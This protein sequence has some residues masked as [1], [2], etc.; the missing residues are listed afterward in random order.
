MRVKTPKCPIDLIKGHP[1]TQLLPV[2]LIKKA[3]IAAL[4]NSD[5]LTAKS[6]LLYGPDA[7]YQPLR[8]NIASWLSEFYKSYTSVT[9]DRIC[10]TGGASQ[11]LACALQVYS[12]PIYTRNIWMVSP[13]YFHASRI[14]EDSGFMGKLKSVPEDAEGIDIDFLARGLDESEERAKREGNVQPVGE[15]SL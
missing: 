14:F 1:S 10:I 5:T 9:A 3:S 11:N 2:D 13:T 6:G 12:D 15:I 7:G 4:S 8:E